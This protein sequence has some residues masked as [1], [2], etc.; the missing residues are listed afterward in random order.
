MHSSKRSL[1]RGPG[2]H[3]PDLG[4][5]PPLMLASMLEGPYR[6]R[7]KRISA[8]IAGI[9]LAV[10]LVAWVLWALMWGQTPFRW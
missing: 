7:G 6:R 9:A 1:I 10:G 2:S 4:P 5:L 8:R 3:P